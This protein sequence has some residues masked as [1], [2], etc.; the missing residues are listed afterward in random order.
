MEHCCHLVFLKVTKLEHIML[1][2]RAKTQWLKGETNVPVFFSKVATRRASKRIYQILNEEGRTYLDPNEDKAPEPD[3]YSSGFYKAAWSVVGDESFT[4]AFVSGRL[5][6]DNI[7]LAQELFLGYKQARLPPKC[8]LKVD[9]RKAYDTLEWD[10]MLATLRL[11]GFPEVL[12]HWIEECVSTAHF[13]VC[14]NGTSHGFFAGARGLRQGDPMSPYLFVLIMEV[15]QPGREALLASLGFQEGHLP[16]RY[17]GLSLIASRLTISDC[18]PLLQKIDSRIHGWDD[19]RLSF[20]GKVQLIKSV[21]KALEVYWAIAFILPKGVIKEIEKQL[22]S[23]LWKGTASSGY[24]KVAWD[25][26]CKPLAKG[27]PRAQGYSCP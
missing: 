19:I 16:V 5:I 18:Q 14:L 10:F 12:V 4:K 2:Q 23:F 9:L 25:Q 24:S 8:A 6:G 27:G 15:A 22:R 13:S 11:F 17:L 1:Q 26:V 21:L 7:L 3:G 20:V